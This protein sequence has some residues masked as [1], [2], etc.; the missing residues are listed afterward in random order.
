MAI[1]LCSGT[2]PAIPF[3]V[4][5]CW[6]EYKEYKLYLFGLDVSTGIGGA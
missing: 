4:F 1:F 3:D 6:S 5:E 2:R